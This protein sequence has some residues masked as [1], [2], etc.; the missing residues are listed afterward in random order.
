MKKALSLVLLLPLTA[1]AA[2]QTGTTGDGT[3]VAAATDSRELR[4]GFKLLAH[5]RNYLLPLTYNASLNQDRWQAL[6][7]NADQDKKEVKFQFSIKLG[8]VDNLFGDN[9]DLYFGYTQQSLW[10]AYNQDAS[11]PFRETNYQPEFFIEFE[12]DTRLLGWTN[13]SNTF[14]VEHQ[15]N[16]RSDPLSRSWNR[17]YAETEW[18]QGDWRLLARP[19]W[20]IPENS[21]DDDNPDIH[22]YMGH[23][24]LTAI[25]RH[26]DHEFTLIGRGNPEYGHFGGQLDWS[27]PIG[28][29]KVRGYVQLY[30]GYG[31]SLVDYDHKVNRVGF[32]FLLFGHQK[33]FP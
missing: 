4:Q 19:F 31:E 8:L 7:P 29:D 32:G 23:L 26:Q 13:I 17:V 12:N 15:S 9:G 10:Q 18:E 2:P 1:I 6:Q 11:S 33:R 5:K 28:L 30:H 20:R 21:A 14:G 27:F 24:D 3:P 16:G 25:Y 22:H